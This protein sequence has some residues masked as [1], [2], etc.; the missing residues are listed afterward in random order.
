MKIFLR[1]GNVLVIIL[2][3]LLVFIALDHFN[4]LPSQIFSDSDFDIEFIPSSKDA[5]ADGVV[6]YSDILNCAREFVGQK[7]KYKSAYYSGGYPDD[8]YYVCTD[9][10]WYA[11]KEAGYD[12]KSLIDEDIKNNKEDYDIDIQD[13]NIDFRRVRNIQVFLDKY[14]EKLTTD[15]EDIAAWQGGDIVVYE[16]HIGIVSDKRNEDGQ[17][18]LIHHDGYHKYEEDGLTRKKIIGH[19]RFN[20]NLDDLNIE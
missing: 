18:Y 14:T 11:L 19:Y 8:D 5:D 9:L 1:F 15:A 3:L 16:N 20:L 7:P 10:I 12:F 6:D 4:Y 17:N 2:I 13:T